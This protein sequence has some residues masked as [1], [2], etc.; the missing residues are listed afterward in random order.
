MR[1]TRPSVLL[2]IGGCVTMVVLT[3]RSLVRLWQRWRRV[4]CVVAPELRSYL[5]ALPLPYPSRRPLRLLRRMPI[6]ASALPGVRCEVMEAVLPGR[7]STLMHV[8]TP[9]GKVDAPR[10]ALLWIHGGGFVFGTPAMGHQ[11]CS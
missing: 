1:A 10:G 9:E 6:P 11:F 5:L 2:R 4:K 3:T 8:Y 7:T